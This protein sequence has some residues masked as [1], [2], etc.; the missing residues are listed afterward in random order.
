MK[1]TLQ[2]CITSPINWKVITVVRNSSLLYAKCNG[3]K[4]IP[5]TCLRSPQGCETSKIPNFLENLLT[6]GCEVVSL[7]RR[8]SFAFRIISDTPLYERLS[9]SYCYSVAGKTK[10]IEKSSDLNE[11]RTRDLPACSLVPQPTTHPLL[12][13]DWSWPLCTVPEAC[14]QNKIG[15]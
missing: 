9:R 11:T 1:Q 12:K 2:H 8:P 5:V 15:E 6:D 14:R 3:R 13:L 4:T 10:W 7:P